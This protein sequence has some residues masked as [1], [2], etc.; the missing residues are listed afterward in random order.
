MGKIAFVG[1]GRMASAMVDGLLAKNPAD[2]SRIAC[3]SASGTSAAAL[4]ARTGIPQA[5]D[6]PE[7]LQEADLVVI[8]FKPQHLAAADSR[9]AE[10]TA[11]KLVLSVLAAKT[12]EHLEAVFPQARAIVRTMPNT[13][14]A[15]GA[16]ITGWCTRTP[17]TEADRVLVLGLLGAIGQAIEVPESK[18]DALMGV[19]GC[20]PAFVFEF[21]AALRDGGIAAGLTPE[22]AGKLATETVL[23]AARLMARSEQTPEALRDQVTSPNGTTFAGL[24]RMAAHDLRGIMKETVLAAKA[25]SEELARGV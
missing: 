9:L 7:L 24:Q 21:T 6:L 14:S 13:P 5:L 12:I 19:S 18:I 8:A 2:R 25:R 3:Y 10:L 22:E 4:S 20:G 17:L 1:A 23:G 16:G 15:I 11:G